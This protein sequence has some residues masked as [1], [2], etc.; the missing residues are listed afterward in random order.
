MMKRTIAIIAPMFDEKHYH[1]DFNLR[2]K[3]DNR[4]LTLAVLYEL[5][6]N[7][8]QPQMVAKQTN[9]R[10]ETIPAAGYYLTGLL[11]AN[12]Y[13]TILG[14]KCDHEFLSKIS[15][16]DLFAI[17]ISSTMI[18]DKAFLEDMVRQ[19]RQF[20]PQA[21]IIVGG[22]FVYKSFYTLLEMQNT[23]VDASHDDSWMLFNNGSEMDV[24]IFV[25]ASNGTPSLLK[26]LKELERGKKAQ[27]EYIPN[28]AVANHKRGFTFTPRQNEMID[29]DKDITRWDLVDKLPMNI[30]IRTSIG[31]PYRCRFCN[32]FRLFPK[33]YLRSKE[34]LRLEL[35]TLRKRPGGKS[36]IIH[37]TD[38]N[39]FINEKRVEDVCEAFTEANILWMGFMRAST[40]NPGNINRIKR[41]GLIGS[42]VGVESGDA[43]Q[44]QRMNKNQTL[45]Q[46]RQGIELLDHNGITVL[47]TFVV[48]FPGETAATLE[49]TANFINGLS[50]GSSCS[51]YQLYPLCIFPLS[52][53]TKP[54]F[55]KKWKMTGFLD[56]WS[57]YTMNSREA[58]EYGYNL[59]KQIPN[60]PYNYSEESNF[61]NSRLFTDP[62]KQTLF[63]L[64]QKL[65]VQLIEQSSWE[66]IAAT[67]ADISQSM[68]FSQ[69]HVN[70]NFRHELIVPAIGR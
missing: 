27:F 63:N 43:A 55:R 19:I 30:P 11:R 62:Q 32:F 8:F 65:T 14:S 39:V 51:N 3:K 25:V 47:M 21:F 61:F 45:E 60:V 16:A 4:E 24:D 13:D 15:S 49:N 50:I 38:D 46:T 70:E 6:K 36:K 44:L 68:G 34:S 66:Q 54:E 57:H 35:Q 37:V 58:I 64:R 18:V 69:R 56:S 29:Y 28:L 26:V 41:S 52:D 12:G 20:L 40:I 2:L 10:A 5:A 1:M 33:I 48:G 9:S 53:L 22:V 31:C 42:L 7:K 17:C 23:E 67:L 59:F